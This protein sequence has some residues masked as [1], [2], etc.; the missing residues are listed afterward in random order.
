MQRT[1]LILA[2]RAYLDHETP[3]SAGS[4]SSGGNGGLLA[5]LRPVIE[6]WDGTSGTTWIGAGLGQFDSEWTDARGF[7]L[8][9]T[10]RGTLRHRRLFFPNATWQGHYA[11][12]SN[13]FLWPLVHLVRHVRGDTKPSYAGDAGAAQI[14]Q[15]PIR[16]A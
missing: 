4:T 2:N 1:G 14:M 16:D 13:S 9:E 7:E 11:E 5:T 15:P 6:P 10:P 8:I 3:R 12:V